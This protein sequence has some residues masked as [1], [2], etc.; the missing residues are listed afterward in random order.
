MQEAYR[1]LDVAFPVQRIAPGEQVA[2]DTHVL[3]HHFQLDRRHAHHVAAGEPGAHA[4]NHAPRREFMRLNYSNRP[5]ALIEEGIARLG[6]VVRQ[7]LD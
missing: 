2:N 7:R 4:Q 6:R 5:P 3:A 1:P